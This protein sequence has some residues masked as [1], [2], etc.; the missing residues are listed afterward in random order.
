M[1]SRP[2]FILLLS[3]FASLYQVSL[4]T[5]LHTS[6]GRSPLGGLGDVHVQRNQPLRRDLDELTLDEREQSRRLENDSA[7]T[8]QA[9]DASWLHE[10][11]SL[12]NSDLDHLLEE[13]GLSY[14]DVREL[15]KRYAA[16]D[17]PTC[18]SSSR[19]TSAPTSTAPPQTSPTGSSSGPVGSR[20][21]NVV[22]Y[23]QTPATGQV[24]LSNICADPTIDVIV[25]SFI[26][27][28]YTKGGYPTVSLAISSPGSNL[29][30]EALTNPS[31]TWH[32]N[33]GPPTQPKSPPV[34]Q[35]CSIAWEMV[36]Q[37]KW[38]PARKQARR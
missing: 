25:L 10:H 35:A 19:P 20:N 21:M 7:D 34:P 29:G 9:E 4:A 8:T 24:P 1:T 27:D 23:A 11:S 28:F 26:T 13:L 17:P 31:S 6:H 15:V 30:D 32:R 12:E 22:Y 33:A 36:S 37:A 2:A 14:G 16:G 38:H 3:A 5:P 18:T